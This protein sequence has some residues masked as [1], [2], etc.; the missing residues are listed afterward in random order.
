MSYDNAKVKIFSCISVWVEISWYHH[1][2]KFCELICL[3]IHP[4]WSF[5]HQPMYVVCRQQFAL[6]DMFSET[7]RPTRDLIFGIK[8][9]LGNFTIFIRM[10][11]QGSKM[12]MRRR[13]RA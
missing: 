10:A 8:H 4:K 6:N 3:C 2:P 12:G 1:E 9:C 5:C 13:A 11:A 7:T